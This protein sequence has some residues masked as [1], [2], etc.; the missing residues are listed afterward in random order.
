MTKDTNEPTTYERSV[1]MHLDTC[2]AEIRGRTYRL[3]EALDQV[4]ESFT[5]DELMIAIERATGLRVSLPTLRQWKK[6]HEGA[7]ESGA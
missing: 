7:Q 3:Y 6:R 4:G 1:A 5:W 2:A